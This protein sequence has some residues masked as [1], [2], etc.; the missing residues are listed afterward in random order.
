MLEIEFAQLSHPGL[1]RTRNEDYLGFVI[2]STSE[3]ARSHGWLFALADG[4]G[5]HRQGEVA[6]RAAI[7]EV[8]AGFRR[9]RAM[10]PPGSLLTRLVQAANARVCETEALAG[11]SGT[12]MASTIVAC[13][14][15]FDRA[16]IAHVGDSRCYVIRHNQV[17]FVTRDHTVA[18]EQLQLGILSRGEA[19]AALTRNILS[20]SLGNQ[21]VVNIETDALQVNAG[22]VLLLSSDGLHGA[23]TEQEILENIG[24][25]RNLDNAARKL[26][27]IANQQDGSDNVS[28]QLIRI[29]NVE[30]IGMYRGRPYKL[31]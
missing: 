5:G 22:D 30:H 28:V 26:V 16:V 23:L 31:H 2:P 7:E 24:R 12:G 4:V 29:V 18:N 6:S 1:V 14:L 27:E 11:P 19:Q 8:V 20:R 21:L 25:N 13:V 3:D 15:R 9:A 17:H 10:D